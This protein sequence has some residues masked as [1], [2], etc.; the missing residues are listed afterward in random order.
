MLIVFV[1]LAAVCWLV[2]AA[3][4]QQLAPSR[5][6]RPSLPEP[7]RLADDPAVPLAEVVTAAEQEAGRQ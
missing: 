5:Y 1:V 6:C 4:R 3:I 2:L 7:Y